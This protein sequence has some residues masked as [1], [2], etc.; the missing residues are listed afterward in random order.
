[1]RR[2]QPTRPLRGATIFRRCSFSR[3]LFQPTRPLRGATA[4]EDLTGLTFRISTHAPL[5]GRDRVPRP[6]SSR[7]QISTH[8]PLAGR[9]SKSVQITMHIFAITDKFQIFSRRMPPVRAL[10]FFSMQKNHADL[11]ANRP[12]DLCTLLLRTIRSSVLP[13]GR[14]ACSQNA[15]FYSHTFSR[16][17]RNADCLFPDP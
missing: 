3:C 4:L 5:A 12:G 10:C 2:F 11:G 14:S 15:Q 13:E 16:D 8:A 1:M 9:D 17:N 6:Q 7:I